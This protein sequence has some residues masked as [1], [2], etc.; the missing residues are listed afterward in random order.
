MR[1]LY[2][3]LFIVFSFYFKTILTPFFFDRF[4]VSLSLGERSSEIIGHKDLSQKKT[5][6]QINGGGGGC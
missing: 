6:Q 3:K 1:F 4:L 5:R 2:P